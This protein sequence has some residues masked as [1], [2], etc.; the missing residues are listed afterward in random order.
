MDIKVSEIPVS[1]PNY[2][3]AI[4]GTFLKISE[5]IDVYQTFIVCLRVRLAKLIKNVL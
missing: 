2:I 1:N 5:A 4:F 3:S